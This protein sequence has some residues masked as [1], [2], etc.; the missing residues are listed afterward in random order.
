MLS[1]SLEF[2]ILKGHFHV[3][4]MGIQLH[5]VEAADQV[6][7]TCC[8]LHSFLLEAHGLDKEWEKG[9]CSDW[10]LIIEL[11]LWEGSLGEHSEAGVF[12]HLGENNEDWTLFDTSGMMGVGNDA[13]VPEVGGNRDDSEHE[14]C[15]FITLGMGA[16]DD[17]VQRKQDYVAI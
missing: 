7:K 6:W 2:W 17:F 13:I 11:L 4:K 5:G 8:A 3:L 15:E 16:T 12:Q 1:V 14:N 10:I 9:V